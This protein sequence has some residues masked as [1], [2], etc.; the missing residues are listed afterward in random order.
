MN[1]GTHLLNPRNMSGDVLD[2]DRILYGEAMA[3]A[4]H[5]CLVDKNTSIGSETWSGRWLVASSRFYVV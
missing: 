2:C 5:P 1:H 3:L 4:F